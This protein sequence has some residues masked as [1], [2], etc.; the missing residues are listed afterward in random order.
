MQLC[1]II[2]GNYVRH[3]GLAALGIVLASPVSAE[4]VMAQPVALPSGDIGNVALSLIVIIA[5]ILAIGWF[6]SRMHGM[7]GPRGQV[8]Q[9]LA[10]QTLGSKERVILVRIADKQLVLGVTAT[11]MQTLLVLDDNND[12]APEPEPEEPLRN[13]FAAR[14]KSALSR[15][16][17]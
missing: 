11:Q 1:D 4:N 17:Q 9:I 15:G 13:S 10:T 12:D 14:M 5:A 7:R 2:D 6:F 8:M 16:A 3:S